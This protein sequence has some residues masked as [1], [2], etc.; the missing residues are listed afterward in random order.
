LLG[1]WAG[2]RLPYWL[3]VLGQEFLK[4]ENCPFKPPAF[5]KVR[6]LW[7]NSEHGLLLAQA[8]ARSVG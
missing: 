6:A 2:D 1:L 4:A 8:I 3:P 7:M 5:G